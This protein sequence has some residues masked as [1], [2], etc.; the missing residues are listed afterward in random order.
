LTPGPAGEL[1]ALPQTPSWIKGW[2]RGTGEQQGKGWKGKAEGRDKE[3]I[4]EGDK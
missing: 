4:R 1:T 3:G 2:D